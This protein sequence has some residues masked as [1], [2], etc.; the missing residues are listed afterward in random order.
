MFCGE[1]RNT[2]QLLLLEGI[3]E[4]VSQNQL[5]LNTW[6][7][8][9]VIMPSQASASGPF[10]LEFLF[11][12]KQW[13][14]LL[15]S[16]F[17]PALHPSQAGNRVC[18]SSRDAVWLCVAYIWDLSLITSQL[19]CRGKILCLQHP[20]YWSV[21]HTRCQQLVAGSTLPCDPVWIGNI[22]V[23]WEQIKLTVGSHKKKTCFC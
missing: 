21:G 16:S 9:N 20:R 2:F 22:W 10:E 4:N 15:S 1:I 7:R 5:D 8:R 3:Y 23:S 11:C 12:C 14:Y 18:C 13:K 19:F 6:G 17:P